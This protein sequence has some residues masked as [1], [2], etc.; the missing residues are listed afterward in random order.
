MKI[1]DLL[2]KIANGE[3][4]PKKV[5]YRKCIF[6]YD[7]KYK[8]YFA[9]NGTPITFD[10]DGIFRNIFADY[11]NFLNNE[12]E[13]IEEK[14][15]Q[16]EIKEYTNKFLEAWKPVK[17]QFGKLFDELLRIG[18]DFN[19]EDESEEEKKIPEKFKVHSL[20]DKDENGNFVSS[21]F[22]T[23]EEFMNKTNEIIDYLHYLKSK[24]E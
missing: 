6:E 13:I 11:S 20:G 23:D 4:V 1:I 8:D 24:G 3:E 22:P 15:T 17:K 14:P 5:K 9:K 12:V 21:P 2:N 19:L 18:N 10:S 7:E 16:E